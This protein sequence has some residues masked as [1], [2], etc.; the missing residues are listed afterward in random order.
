MNKYIYF[1]AFILVGLFF[2]MQVQ[3]VA[4]QCAM[5]T[6]NA[7]NSVENGNTFG[8]GLNRGILFL[9]VMPF[10]LLTGVFLLWYF[11]FRKTPSIEG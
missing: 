1:L 2:F 7:E 11:K 8:L 10:L 5:C 4:A 9:L 6:L 3:D